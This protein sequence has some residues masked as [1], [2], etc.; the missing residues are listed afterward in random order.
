MR[1]RKVTDR[2][3]HGCTPSVPAG[4]LLVSCSYIPFSTDP[5]KKENKEKRKN[6]KIDLTVDRIPPHETIIIRTRDFLFR[7]IKGEG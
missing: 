2:A 1:G 7:F 3:G 4:D 5:E 6:K